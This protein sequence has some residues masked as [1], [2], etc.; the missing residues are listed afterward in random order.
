MKKITKIT[1]TVDNWGG[2]DTYETPSEIKVY[3]EDPSYFSD[4][5]SFEFEENG[6]KGVCFI[7]DLIGQEVMV[8]EEVILVEEE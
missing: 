4:D 8:G 3:L 7:D 6:N 2:V 5:A 1:E